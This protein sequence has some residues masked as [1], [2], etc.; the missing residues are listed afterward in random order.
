M[1]G[2]V[3]NGF[4]FCKSKKF[5]KDSEPILAF[6]HNFFKQMKPQFESSVGH[7]KVFNNRMPIL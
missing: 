6:L 3:V 4:V 5:L 1:P 2:R 7:T